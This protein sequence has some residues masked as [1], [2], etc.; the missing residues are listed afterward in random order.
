MGKRL[1]VSPLAST[2]HFNLR[3][4]NEIHESEND[5]LS[6]VIY[7]QYLEK[8][9]SE[10]NSEINHLKEKEEEIAEIAALESRADEFMQEIEESSLLQSVPSTKVLTEEAVNG[11]YG[12]KDGDFGNLVTANEQALSF[13]Q[14]LNQVQNSGNQMDDMPFSLSYE[15][16]IEKYQETRLLLE[17]YHKQILN[18]LDRLSDN[19]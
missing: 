11:E 6:R 15:E 18:K 8:A 5:S 9:A 13:V 2:L 7:S 10:L 19:K 12:S 3:Q 17:D 14:L 1:Q 16:I 4:L